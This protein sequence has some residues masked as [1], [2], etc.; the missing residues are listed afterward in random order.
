MQREGARPTE[1]FSQETSQLQRE[2]ER[3][4]G[5]GVLGTMGETL[6]VIS[7]AVGET[8]VEIAENTKNIVVGQSQSGMGESGEQE[9]GSSDQQSRRSSEQQGK[10]GET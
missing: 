4:G 5:T 3:E 1:K 8:L 7:G 6:G 2:G 9:R 10:Q